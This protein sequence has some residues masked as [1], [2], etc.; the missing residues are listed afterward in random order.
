MSNRTEYVALAQNGWSKSISLEHKV[1]INLDFSNEAQKS[2]HLDHPMQSYGQIFVTCA[3]R[4]R[5]IIN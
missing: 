2:G 3:P 4:A 5:Y 1:F